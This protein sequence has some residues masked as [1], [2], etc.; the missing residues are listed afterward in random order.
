MSEH[1]ICEN[2]ILE[3]T[4]LTGEDLQHLGSCVSCSLLQENVRKS[5]DLLKQAAAVSPREGF[6]Q[7][8]WELKARKE[9]ER[10]KALNRKICLVLG[11]LIGVAA[12]SVCL[13][14]L[15]PG[16]FGAVLEIYRVYLTDVLVISEKLRKILEALGTPLRTICIAAFVLICMDAV[17]LFV[18]GMLFRERHTHERKL[19]NAEE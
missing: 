19:G 5:E 2:R 13:L 18:T 1:L 8:F 16:N 3:G 14:A 17:I 11:L 7:R 6:A 10:E 15:L 12:L 9:A 4:D